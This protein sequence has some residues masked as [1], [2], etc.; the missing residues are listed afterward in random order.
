MAGLRQVPLAA[1]RSII[2]VAGVQEE[3]TDV[4]SS[5]ETAVP[6]DSM[7]VCYWGKNGLNAD[8]ALRQFVPRSDHLPFFH[9]LL[10]SATGGGGEYTFAPRQ[11]LRTHLIAF[12]DRSWACANGKNRSVSAI[13]LASL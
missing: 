12:R 13:I 8:V 4:S 7:H 10:E 2:P 9:Y 6:T 3:R 1:L 5:Y 11:L